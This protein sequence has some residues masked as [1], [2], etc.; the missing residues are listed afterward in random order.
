[1]F[2]PLAVLAFALTA[3]YVIPFNMFDHSERLS[4]DTVIQLV[5]STDASA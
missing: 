4:V 2:A 3:W 5:A 1:M